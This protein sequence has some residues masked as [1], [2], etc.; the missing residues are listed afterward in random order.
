MK[1]VALTLASF[2]ATA[3][4]GAVD[5]AVE[6]QYASA[7]GRILGE[8]IVSGRAFET[9]RHLTDRIGPRLSGSPGAA[10]AVKWTAERMREDGLDV[11]TEAVMVP[12]W[13][14]GIET[15]EIL[16]PV[17]HKL[18]ITALGGSEPTPEGGLEGEVVEVSSFDELR[19]KG[20][21]AVKGR[22]VLYNKA[23]HAGSPEEG[24]GAV[25]PLR[26][27]GAV[28]AA[29]LGA[30]GSLVRSLGTYSMRIPHT[31]A[32]QYEDGV[33]RIPSAAISAEDAELIHR[34]IEDGGPVR[35]RFV[36]GCATL[37]DVESANVVADFKGRDKPDEIVLIGAHLDSWDLGTGAIDDGAGVAVV[38]EALRLLKSLGLQPRRT[39]RGVLFMNEENGLRGGEGYAKAHAAE[40]SRHV[41]AIESDGGGARPVGFSA[42][43]GEG[44]LAFVRA[45]A[46][47][48]KPIGADNAIAGGFGGADISPMRAAGVPL[49]GLGQEPTH[50]F[51][52]HHTAADTLDKVD[53]YELKLNA[54]AM[55]LMAYALAEHPVPL[56]RPTPP[57]ATPT[58]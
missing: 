14:R 25:S 46:R 55:A 43:A 30:V 37:P 11:R 51:D 24:Y 6:K 23:I 19:A 45:V 3:T 38:M 32:M 54:A 34:L 7:A 8:E 33:P 26:T 10:A 29:R 22:I 41:A 16:G 1:L 48:L 18:A 44:G 57:P 40:L 35:V 58:R 21:A 20:A 12:R 53:P 31:G 47:L 4:V 52:W 13:T 50:Y 36:L 28:E 49:L 5:D 42:W 17:G 56:P 9:L 15:G 27:K 39:I 2:A